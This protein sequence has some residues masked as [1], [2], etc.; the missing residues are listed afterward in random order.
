MNL[1]N[2]GMASSLNNSL[3]YRHSG[4]TWKT[5]P[6]NILKDVQITIPSNAQFWQHMVFSL[7]KIYLRNSAIGFDQFREETKGKA[8]L[9]VFAFFIQLCD[10]ICQ[11]GMDPI[12]QDCAVF[13]EWVKSDTTDKHVGIRVHLFANRTTKKNAQSIIT[14]MIAANAE[15]AKKQ[16][17]K[18]IANTM[19]WD[20]W[21]TITTYHDYA[22]QI[23]DVYSKNYK[24]SSDMDNCR[25]GNLDHQAHPLTVFSLSNQTFQISGGNEQQNN[26]ENYM[27]GTGYSFPDMNRVYRMMPSDLN[28]DKFFRKYLPDYFFT[29]V[30]FPEAI[31]YPAEHINNTMVFNMYIA[32]HL[33]R[34]R[35][36]ARLNSS[37]IKTDADS[38][39]W[40]FRI[41]HKNEICDMLKDHF[42]CY[43]SNDDVVEV[44]GSGAG[45][46]WLTVTS[47]MDNMKFHDSSMTAD[48]K[49][50][51]SP[52]IQTLL[53]D[54]HS[55]SDIDILRIR[56]K[57]KLEYIKDR[58]RFQEEM[59]ESF[60]ERVWDD[61]HADV[62]EPA[63]MI[64]LWKSNIR[65][66]SDMNFRFKKMDP[67]MSIFANRVIRVL[68]F[69][70]NGLF[71]SSQHKTLFLL[72]H[73]KYDAYRQETNLHFN[74]T[75]TGEGATSKSYMFDK[76]AE[77]S[78]TGTISTLTY[79]TNRSDAIDGD[80]IDTIEVFNEAP[81]GMFMTNAKTD[82]TQEA[83][84]K[85]K[86]T[87]QVVKVK[88]FWRDENTGE[89]KNRIAKSQAIGVVMG[90]TND[91]PSDCSEAMATRFFWGQF[92]KVEGMG[93]SIQ[94]CMRGD[95]EL[96]DCDEASNYKEKML[97]YF[98]EEQMRMWLVLK[99]MYM[100]ILKKP[101]LKA[102]DIVYAQMTNVLKKEYKVNIP[103]RTKER[104]EIL[105]SIFTIIN[106]LEMQFNTE[107]GLHSGT[108][109][110]PNIFHPIQLL[111]IEP[112]LF[113][114][115]EIA[116][117][118]LTH[119]S[120]EIVNPNEY[121]VMKAIWELHKKSMEY[122]EDVT[123]TDDGKRIS[124]P[125]YNYIKLNNGKR[126]LT[127]IINAIPASSGKMSKHNVKGIMDDWNERCITCPIYQEMSQIL[128]RDRKYDDMYPEP[129]DGNR[130]K[131]IALI[132]EDR[133]TLVH[134][135]L[136]HNIRKNMYVNIVKESIK[137]L[138]HKFADKKRKY[139]MGS[140]LRAM[141]I[142]KYPHLLD[143]ITLKRDNNRQITLI[144]PLY[145][146][147][148]S[149][150][151]S[152]IKNLDKKQKQKRDF[153]RMDL[154]A[155]G[156]I[157]HA[158]ILGKGPGYGK[159]CL[160]KYVEFSVE[161][162]VI[163]YPK[164]L[165]DLMKQPANNNNEDD[166]DV[167]GFTQEDFDKLEVENVFGRPTKRTRLI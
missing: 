29:R 75:Y 28:I 54:K 143:T 150:M 152:N 130:D 114:T 165:I 88:E 109:D 89:R 101:T 138:Q 96:K 133:N 16:S 167:D 49:P 18:F 65:K 166:M 64:L 22:A 74:Q 110:S 63:R 41:E 39:T 55:L 12:G 100:G 38:E 111:D 141:S 76:M 46:N 35:Y 134:V 86:L 30:K 13:L 93:R 154:S 148:T 9:K 59:V 144:N 131:K 108:E 24:A 95:R 82:G 17:R 21:K 31:C 125:D 160:E 107:G 83:M 84:F 162:H 118:A 115:E 1:S 70:N 122:R 14:E 40:T 26:P 117:F 145:M 53:T 19:D 58:R 113:C 153:I 97:S 124:V 149:Q 27:M 140:C 123:I 48:S 105:C 127:E 159:G 34:D 69:Y 85:N 102:A 2:K 23:C 156:A 132:Y 135:H 73:S 15:F 103:P 67:D 10:N 91:N 136:F 112:L 98:K 106:A 121:K 43:R 151:M 52:L 92:E 7:D 116:V 57:Y 20:S 87:E 161:E 56:G 79:Q 3:N 44:G 163:D 33:D 8:M 45:E 139:I 51:I 164:T 120:E 11:E 146:N 155:Q 77:M 42:T 66:D 4:R 61:V 94:E 6:F 68:H 147:K 80:Q 72:N 128:P 104:F 5:T 129:I 81:P 90:A 137:S 158:N 119:I 71:V 78:I 37:A 25:Y 99:F 142:V 157:T 60:C 36:L 32:P 47:K 50:I 62:S 126:L